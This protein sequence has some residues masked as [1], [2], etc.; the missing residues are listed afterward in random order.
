MKATVDDPEFRQGNKFWG[1]NIVEVVKRIHV[2]KVRRAET[3]VCD[4]TALTDFITK[5]F[6]LLLWSHLIAISHTI[7]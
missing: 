6:L 2:S 5:S 3:E 1:W 7:H 4:L